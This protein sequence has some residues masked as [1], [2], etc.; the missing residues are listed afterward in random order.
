MSDGADDTP[1]A[2][3]SAEPDPELLAAMAA[4]GHVVDPDAAAGGSGGDGGGGDG[5]S[6]AAAGAA[7]GGDR[8][9]RGWLIAGLAL[10]VGSAAAAV[11]LAGNGGD[12]LVESTAIAPIRTTTTISRFATDLDDAGAGRD[13][14]AT[15]DP[16]TST[17]S[18]VATTTSV[19]PATAPPQDDDDPAVVARPT[20]VEPPPPA[21]S[22]PKPP[23]ADSTFTTSAGLL[24]TDVGCADDT[25][26]A[27]LD[28]FFS[29]RVGP[30]LGWD[31]Q[32]VVSL[33]A[34]RSLW[35]FQDTFLDHSG[36]ASTLDKSSFAHNVAVLEQNGCFTLLHRGSTTRPTPF[37]PGTGSSTLSTWFWPM[38]GELI[39]G[40]VRVVWAQMVKDAV[41]PTPPDGLGWHPAAT[42]IATYDPDTLQ[43]LDF[44]QAPNAGVAPIYGYAVVSDATHTYLFGNT[45]EQNL[46]R[47]G[48]YWNG[49]HSATQVYLAR[50]PRGRIFDNPEYRTADGW[51]PDP[52][53]SVPILSRH[54]AEFPF[55]PRY[56]DGQWVGVAAVDGYW[57]EQYSV[58]VANQPWGPW[59][60]VESREIAPRNGD[61]KMNTYHA[62]LLPTRDARGQLVVT[63]SNNARNMLRDAWPRPDRYRPMVFTSAWV[64]APADPPPVTT[65][66]ST[67]STTTIPATTTSTTTTTTTTTVPATT[68]SPTST[69][70]TTVPA[71][72]T[73]A[74]AF[75]TTTSTTSTTSTTV[76]AADE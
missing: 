74:P 19:P 39:D 57:D 15:T 5:D 72:T 69:T 66:T 58:D 53:A 41:D 35:L 34:T 70:T 7:S 14:A 24:S 61:P 67:T 38:G 13:D 23:W 45:F 2:G 51:S 33:G 28:R 71:T 30:V 48:G 59:T 20:P 65:T 46:S 73:T 3:V 6:D 64:G 44:R 49:P 12:P 8:S 1:V 11:V 52:A 60:T 9:T 4:A 63:I 26:A 31:Y 16:S 54:W 42:Y 17:T 75:T 55:Q 37:E 40:Q 27:G 21:P 10:V 32:H 62:H 36:T 18:E 56:L 29:Q 22:A 43:R 50:V 25:S 68:T 76:S 47:E